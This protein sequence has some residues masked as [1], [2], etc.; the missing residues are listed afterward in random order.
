M[1][2]VRAVVQAEAA[3]LLADPLIGALVQRLIRAST[4]AW[5]HSLQTAEMAGRLMKATGGSDRDVLDAVRGG[6]LHD[7]GKATLP[8]DVLNKAGIL[9]PEEWEM[10]KTHPK[11]GYDLLSPF[12]RLSPFLNDRI[13]DVVLHHRERYDGSGYPDGLSGGAVA[14]LT[15]A[16]AVADVWD[17]LTSARSYRAPYP[18]DKALVILSSSDL[19]HRY[20]AAL[21]R[22]VSAEATS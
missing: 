21:M 8:P 10:T 14:Q 13:L 18:R 3:Q 16:T 22:L 7:V 5:D 17:A 12:S 6:L 1:A 19:D 2:P 11:V 9:S 4:A 20:V 15:A